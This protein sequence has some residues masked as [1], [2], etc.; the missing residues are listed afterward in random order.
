MIANTET[1]P[2][3]G[4][5][6]GSTIDQNSAERS[7]AV[8]LRRLEHLARQIVEEALH[9]QDV[10]RVRRR[11]QPDREVVVEQRHVAEQRRVHDR[12]VQRHEQHDRRDE[13]RREHRAV[14]DGRV[15]RAQHRQR[16]PGGRRDEQLRRTRSRR[17][18]RSC[19]R[20]T[21]RC[22]TSFHAVDRFA[23]SMP[24]GQSANGWRSVSC[25]GVTA[26]F[27]SHSSGP[28]P[29]DDEP[30]EE[31]T[32]CTTAIPSSHAAACSRSN[33]RRC[34]GRRARRSDDPLAAPPMPR[35]TGQSPHAARR[36]LRDGRL[37]R[38]HEVLQRSVS[39]KYSQRAGAS[40]I[41]SITLR[42]GRLA[43]VAAQA[44]PERVV[45]R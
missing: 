23:Q 21:G 27:A 43:V 37:G 22:A 45:G 39:L 30:D 24:F 20:S 28:R 1:T 2:R 18:S 41:A 6:I 8:G 9:E 17:R 38:G 42:R 29:G 7:G 13:Q 16:V 4:F 10:E 40:T 34:R 33:P 19:S 3:I 12:E 15:P 36:L 11:R 44:V 25:V 32:T 26:D 35:A 31:R 14:Q 5:D